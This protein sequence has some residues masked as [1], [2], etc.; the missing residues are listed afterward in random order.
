MNESKK[1]I[2]RREFLKK[3]SALGTMGAAFTMGPATNAALLPGNKR[4]LPPLQ[5]M[6]ADDFS[7]LVGSWFRIYGDHGEAFD[8]CLTD[9]CRL[10][11]AA[12]RPPA[13]P[14][15]EAFVAVFKGRGLEALTGRTYRVEHAQSGRFDLLLD[16]VPDAGGRPRVEAVFN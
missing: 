1:N 7:Y 8:V 16:I 5:E 14:R 6:T 10:P 9:V 12:A 2:R 3:M 13:L 15:S 11:S 4:H